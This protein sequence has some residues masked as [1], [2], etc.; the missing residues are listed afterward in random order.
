MN[1]RRLALLAAAAIILAATSSHAADIKS[2]R[3]RSNQANISYQVDI[4]GEIDEYDYD[5]FLTAVRGIP[6]DKTVVILQSP[7]G[8][9]R[10]GIAI[11]N[12]IHTNGFSTF[13]DSGGVCASICAAIWLAG[14]RRFIEAGCYFGFHSSGFGGE[15]SDGGNQ[16]MRKYFHNIGLSN[17]AT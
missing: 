10:A 6:P 15:R 11:G 1:K 8:N 9:V 17:D 13:V 12:Y 2:N 3:L 16:M 14:T 5:R 7:G 4:D